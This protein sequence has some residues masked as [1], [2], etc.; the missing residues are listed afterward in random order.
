M[1]KEVIMS[2]KSGSGP[3]AGKRAAARTGAPKGARGTAGPGSRPRGPMIKWFMERT[4]KLKLFDNMN[5]K[6]TRWTESEGDADKKKTLLALLEIVQ[7]AKEA[8]DDIVAGLG[9]LDSDG[10][11]PPKP[12][13]GAPIMDLP[14][15]RQIWIKPKYES[16]YREAYNDA[17]LNSLFVDRLAGPRRVVVSL[18]EPSPAS[19]KVIIPKLHINVR[20]G[21]A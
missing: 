5:K 16:I 9:E 7:E 19:A 15:G 3:V 18:G 20:K 13:A 10:Y 11:L 1:G 17:T 2:T 6:V 4:S 12:K 14:H 21:V 8:Q